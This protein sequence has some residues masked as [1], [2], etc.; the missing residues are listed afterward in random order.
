MKRKSSFP[1]TT[2][3]SAYQQIQCTIEKITR[4]KL[5]E[6]TGIF[7]HILNVSIAKQYVFQRAKRYMIKLL[8]YTLTRYY[9]KEGCY[10]KAAY[11]RI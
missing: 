2:S 6:K 5:K 10:S 1:L 3:D 8:G 7:E 4:G 11:Q 9:F